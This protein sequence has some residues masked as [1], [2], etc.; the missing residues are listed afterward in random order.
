MRKISKTFQDRAFTS[1]SIPLLKETDDWIYND[2]LLSTA[3]NYQKQFTICL[4]L[5][6]VG[7]F[8]Q[9]YLLRMTNNERADWTN[10]R[11]AAILQ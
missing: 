8:S 4:S 1:P 11:P 6:N 7:P 5:V 9:R 10:M 3:G 2:H